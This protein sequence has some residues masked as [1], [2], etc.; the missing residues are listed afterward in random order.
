MSLWLSSPDV[1]L[2][3]AVAQI[4]GSGAYSSTLSYASQTHSKLSALSVGRG[5]CRQNLGP[6][7]EFKQR[8]KFL[9]VTP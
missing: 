4:Y 5:A 3:K 6:L 9:Y 1:E 2:W 8:A 7:L